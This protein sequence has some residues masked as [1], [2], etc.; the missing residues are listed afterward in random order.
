MS[1]NI[2]IKGG[3]LGLTAG[4]TA[5]LFDGLYMFFPQTYV[6]YEYPFL[7]LITDCCFWTIF[8][9]LSGFLVYLFARKRY[10]F[11]EKERFYWI[12]FFLLPFA[13]LF[14]FLS[15]FNDKQILNPGFDNNLVFLWVVIFIISVIAIRNRVARAEGGVGFF[16]PELLTIIALFNFCSN[17]EQLPV[18][19]ESFEYF[20]TVDF[21]K[22]NA[23]WTQFYNRFCLVLYGAGAFLIVGLYYLISATGKISRSKPT[24][25]F[26]LLFLAA[27]VLLTV[28]YRSNRAA[29]LKQYHVLP[30]TEQ[31]QADHKVPPV[32]LIVLDTVRKRS[33]DSQQE[34][35]TTLRAFARDSVTFE[36]CIANSSWTIPSHASLF[37]GFSLREHGC[38][39]MLESGP[40]FDGFPPPR[41]LSEKFTTLAEVFRANGYHTAAIV[42]NFEQLQPGFK[43]NQGFQIYDYA[44]SIG[45]NFERLPIKPLL[46]FIS[47]ATNIKNKYALPYRKAED[48]NDS[49][50]Y[51]L[52]HL[53][54]GPSFLFVNYMDAH[55]PYRPSR[56]FH[57]YFIDSLL[58]Y[59]YILVRQAGDFWGTVSGTSRCLLNKSLYE[60]EIAYLDHQLGNLFNHLKQMGKYDESLIIITSDHGELFCEHGYNKHKVPCYEGVIHIPLYIKYPRSQVTGSEQQYI[61]LADLYPTILSICGL[62]VPE[63]VSGK[64]FGKPAAPVMAEFYNYDIGPHRA[65]YAGKYKLMHFAKGREP[66]LFDLKADPLEENNLAPR[67]PEKVADMKTMVAEWEKNSPARYQSTDMQEIKVSPSIKENLK[68]LGYVQ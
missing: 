20:F 6:P 40:W 63:G 60:G 25:S 5:S 26:I 42:S 35:L 58:P 41:P 44:K 52:Q 29:F 55:D 43:L 33:I 45:W 4:L 27:A 13:L 31:Q 32:I 34:M 61:M 10:N 67:F 9:S 23:R 7:V 8:G 54:P 53:P 64:A 12:I 11:K 65:L 59:A 15:K 39:G 51:L 3:L 16:I 62:P 30:A 1:K 46:H 28:A 38:H 19:Q 22:D 24:F 47:F 18:V 14:G 2:L 21:L 57:G 17:I 50:Y 56:P 68:A 49:V 37:T 66:E 48:I 36:N